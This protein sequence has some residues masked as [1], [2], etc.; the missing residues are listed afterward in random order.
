[1]IY[2]MLTIK[3]DVRVC[4][5]E[6]L[7]T[8]ALQGIADQETLSLDDLIVSKVLEAVKQ[9][10]NDAPYYMLEGKDFSS[11]S[12]TW[13]TNDTSGVI[14][15][16]VDFMRLVMFEM[17]DWERPVY[18]AISTLSPEYSK[19]KSR[20]KGIRGNAERPVVAI[21]MQPAG[22]TLEF[23]ASKTNQATISRALY[24]PIPVIDINDGVD[25]SEQCYQ[26]VLYMTAGLVK[27][28]MGETEAAKL[29]FELYKNNIE[30]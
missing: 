20:H 26:A 19:Q 30:K 12:V 10:H 13:N 6:N 14:S 27:A 25:I 16:P 21:G 3:H 18:T 29:F 2:Q 8:T 24:M 1:M 15:L 11:E 4:L 9:A 28:T 5:D 23:Y 7:T 17:S 22:R